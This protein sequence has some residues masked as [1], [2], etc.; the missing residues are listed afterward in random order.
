[1]ASSKKPNVVTDQWQLTREIQVRQ[2]QLQ[3][4]LDKFQ[5][6]FGS[7]PI[8]IVNTEQEYDFINPKHYVQED[9]KQT[10]ERMVEKWG[11]EKTA[12]WCEMTAFKYQDRIGKK[13]GEDIER[14]QNKIKW[15]EEKAEE[16]RELAKKKKF[17]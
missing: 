14:E 2:G 17:W 1:M 11:E 13:P 12:L 16:L 9:G 6:H 15:Y 10:W 8:K 4:S 3:E 7:Y 5:N